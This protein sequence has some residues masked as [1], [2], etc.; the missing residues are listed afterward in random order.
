MSNPS[1]KDLSLSPEELHNVSKLL[2]KKEVLRAMKA[3]LNIN[4]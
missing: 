2:A 4:Y 1:L 3:C